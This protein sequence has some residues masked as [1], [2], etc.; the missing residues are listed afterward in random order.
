MIEKLTY[1]LLLLLIFL[2]YQC[3]ENS[4]EGLPPLNVLPESSYYANENG[5][6]DRYHRQILLRGV[7]AESHA[8]W[9]DFHLPAIEEHDF[10][11]MADL[12]M[13]AVR[14]LIMW[15]GLEPEK[16][17]YDFNYID[18][19]EE[20]VEWATDHQL[21]VFLDMHQDLYG[22]GFSGPSD[23]APEW[24]C[25]SYYY[26]TYEPTGGSWFT[27]YFTPQIKA[28]FDHF[29]TDLETQDH[30][31][32]GLELLTERFKDNPHVIG[33]D[34]FNEPSCGN[35]GPEECDAKL[36][37][38]YKRCADAIHAIDP[39]MLIMFSSNQLTFGSLE[40]TNIVA[41]FNNGVYA[42]HYYNTFVEGFKTY[43]NDPDLIELYINTR[44]EEAQRM[45]VPLLLGEWGGHSSTENFVQFVDDSMDIYDKYIASQT[46]WEY[47]YSNGWYGIVDGEGNDKPHVEPLARPFPKAVPGTINFFSFENETKHFE[48]S[49]DYDYRIK[50]PAVIAVPKHHYPNGF[51]IEGCDYPDCHW[52]YKESTGEV[53]LYPRDFRTYLIHIDAQ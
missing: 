13:N 12:G 11:H 15:A 44:A 10:K 18:A 42:P 3:T 52:E 17:Q 45:G 20:I 51:V 7:N 4:F 28:C 25:D 37:S 38:F 8:K 32:G 40:K 50:Q 14:Y 29:W 36:S 49:F 21:L 23:G 24:S 30:F 53:H 48:L 43:N 39:Y 31:I 1:L 9:D 47:T 34:L 35:F 2:C 5:I 46:I 41:D 22:E 19:T 33:F 27:N 26:D 6:F 16:G